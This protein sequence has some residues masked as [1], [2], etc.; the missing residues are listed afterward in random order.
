MKIIAGSASTQLASNIAKQLKMDLT[1]TN[2]QKFSDGELFVEIME[3]VRGKDVF[4]I[5][6][7]SNPANDHLMELLIT[8][9]ALK[10]GSA[11]RIT[12]VMPYYGYARQD[13]KTGART[14]ITAKMVA[15]IIESAGA[16]RVLTMDLHASQIQGFFNIP[17]DNLYARPIFVRDIK[18][19]YGHKLSSTVIVSPD[20]GGVVRARGLAAKLSD[21]TNLAI[22]DKR[23]E[24][25]N[26]AEVM[27][28]IGDV[29]GRDCILIDDMIDTA[30]TLVKGVSALKTHGAA[31]VVAYCSHGVLSGEAYKRIMESDLDELVVTDSIYSNGRMAECNKIRQIT[32]APLMA[33]AIKRVSLSESVSDLFD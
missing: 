11:S 30:G 9:D 22:I 18:E 2:V 14:P 23:R 4:V 6:S 12:A 16:N 31:S 20:A 32:T 28:I 26:H 19:H 3:N 15:D 33:E 27:H 7:T 29:Y 10:R 17:V 25:A 21:D 8:I 24:K 13:R 1:R 5:Q